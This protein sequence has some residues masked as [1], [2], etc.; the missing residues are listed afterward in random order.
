MNIKAFIIPLF[1][2]F[3]TLFYASCH[4][5]AKD[6]REALTE[7]RELSPF[8]RITL[9]V[10][11]VL[12]IQ[13]WTE[14][15]LRIEAE[16]RLLDAIATHADDKGQLIIQLNQ[17]EDSVLSEN[18]GSQPPKFFVTVENLEALQ[19]DGGGKIFGEGKITAKNVDL[20]IIGSGTIHLHIECEHLQS[21]ISG[22]G[23]YSL[24]GEVESQNVKIHGKGVYDALDL[25]SK[26]AELKI[27]GVGEATVNVA[28]RLN[29]QIIGSGKVQYL[30]SPALIQSVMGTG[31]IEEW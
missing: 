29:V 6:E 8:S 7:E 21:S 3:T 16:K 5:S 25:I 12:Y 22:M 18:L 15:S 31:S 19:L 20:A 28:D 9:N 30:G 10:P 17:E 1:L 13:Q 14:S 2:A 11:G 23:Q 26:N 27:Q 4:P 24:R